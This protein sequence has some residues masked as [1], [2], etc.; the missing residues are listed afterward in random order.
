M[1][2][3]VLFA[4]GAGAGAFVS[5]IA[6]FSFIFPTKKECSICRKDLYEEI[7]KLK[8]TKADNSAMAVLT[9]HYHEILKN[10]SEL[11]ATVKM[12]IRQEE[13]K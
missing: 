7:N 4:L 9:S 13:R 10:I 2:N 12:I 8:E 11:N 3:E 5:I 1:K 6:V